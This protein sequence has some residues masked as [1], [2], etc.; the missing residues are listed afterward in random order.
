M[1]TLVEDTENFQTINSSI[2]EFRPK[3]G[4]G[5][6][7]KGGPQDV[8]QDSRYNERE[9]Q[10]EK[11]FFKSIT[12][13]IDDSDS[14]VIFGPAEMGE[15]LYSEIS[16]SNPTLYKKISEVAPADSMTDNQ[17]KAWIRNYFN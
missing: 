15:K 4:S 9:K 2:E 3:G 1:L 11:R 12:D 17:V 6:R 13:V 10:Q 16:E 14:I 7:L 8:V 5:T